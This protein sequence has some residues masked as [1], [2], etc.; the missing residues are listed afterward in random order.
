MADPSKK[1]FDL[2]M[3]TSLDE[4]GK[5]MIHQLAQTEGVSEATVVRHLISERFRMTFNQQPVCANGMNCLC[6]HM[7]MPSKPQSET[8]AELLNRVAQ[9]PA[10]SQSS[11]Y[12]G[13]PAP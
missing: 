12:S 9:N 6:P 10:P 13:D 2:R 11:P 8:D 7:H 5:A 3:N 1:R 4:T